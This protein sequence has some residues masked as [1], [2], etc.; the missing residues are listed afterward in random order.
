MKGERSGKS[1]FADRGKPGLNLL[2]KAKQYR[3][4]SRTYATEFSFG[5]FGRL[6]EY[7]VGRESRFRRRNRWSQGRGLHRPMVARDRRRFSRGREMHMWLDLETSLPVRVRHRRHGPQSRGCLP[8][9][10][11]P[12]GGAGGRNSSTR[13]PRGLRKLPTLDLKVDEITEY[14][15][16]GL[17]TFAKYN[18]ADT[19]P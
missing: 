13:D 6:S 10:E 19:Q 12:L 3:I 14:V 17:S 4:L 11:F 5:L 18:R 2:P 7:K 1:R 16:L 8:A 9:R 15:V